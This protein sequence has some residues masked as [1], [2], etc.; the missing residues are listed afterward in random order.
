MVS[1]PSKKC[2]YRALEASA[3]I[4]HG[5]FNRSAS[6]DCP[7]EINL[8]RPVFP[9]YRLLAAEMTCGKCRIRRL[10]SHVVGA[11]AQDAEIQGFPV[12]GIP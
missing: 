7:I 4:P 3:A 9:D 6:T 10:M 8:G 2:L 1:L 11:A 5:A 12:S